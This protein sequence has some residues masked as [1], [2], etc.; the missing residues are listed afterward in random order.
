MERP[1]NKW[2]RFDLRTDEIKAVLREYRKEDNLRGRPPRLW[3]RFLRWVAFYLSWGGFVIPGLDPR[4]PYL[5]RAYLS[6]K[7][8]WIFP[9]V[10][11]HN[12]FRGDADPHG[13]SHPWRI[14]LSFILARG[15]LEFRINT[16]TGQWTRI[17]RRPWGLVLLG[18][19]TYH[20]VELNNGKAWTLFFTW[21]RVKDDDWYFWVPGRGKVYWEK[22]LDERKRGLL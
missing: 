21:G 16:R 7:L 3:I 1:K 12:F 13:H 17:A 18:R 4:T 14:S 20:R 9:S 22:Y 2:G 10:Y 19:N 11:L 6:P 15:Y 8:W 5:F